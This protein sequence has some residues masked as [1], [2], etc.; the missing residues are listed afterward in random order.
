MD[1]L[2]NRLE[3]LQEQIAQVNHLTPE[4]VEA[5]AAAW[6]QAVNQLAAVVDTLETGQIKRAIYRR[7]LE[8]IINRIPEIQAILL[9]V[10][11]QTAQQIMREHQRVKTVV[12]GYQDKGP[13]AR[14]VKLLR[15]KA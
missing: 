15:T 13:H 7:R 10:K 12:H 9:Q 4:D 8:A 3:A 14:Q 2:L 11:S 5:L 1:E 6:T